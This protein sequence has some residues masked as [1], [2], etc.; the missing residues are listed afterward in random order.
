MCATLLCCARL[1]RDAE[2]RKASELDKVSFPDP[3][4]FYLFDRESC[5]QTETHT[6]T[7][8]HIFI[9]KKCFNSPE[10][11]ALSLEEE[12]G[13]VLKPPFMSMCGRACGNLTLDFKQLGLW[14]SPPFLQTLGPWFPNEIQ[15]LLPSEKT[16]DH[17]ATV[18][19]FFHLAQVRCLWSCLWFKEWLNK[20]NTTTV[21]KFLDSLSPFLVKFTQILESILLDN[22][23]KDAVLSVGCAPFSSTLF[24]LHSTF[25]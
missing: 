2:R 1:R 19:F 4:F 5:V 18:Q 25:C 6:H 20:R 24:P 9:Y 16:L 13:Q 21:A 3:T 15:N 17:W 7:Y 11:R 23:H 10:K 14:A 8:M 12:K 22:P